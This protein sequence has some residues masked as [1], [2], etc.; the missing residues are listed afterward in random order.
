[1]EVNAANCIRTYTSRYK[2]SRIVAGG[3]HG[4]DIAPSP[5]VSSEFGGHTKRGR[6][7]LFRLASLV[8]PRQSCDAKVESPPPTSVVIILPAS[9][10]S[11]V[12]AHGSEVAAKVHN[13]ECGIPSDT[14]THT[15]SSLIYSLIR[16][17]CFVFI[18]I[19]DVCS[20]SRL[21]WPSCFAGVVIQR[22]T[23]CTLRQMNCS[24]IVVVRWQWG[25]RSNV[26]Y[27]SAVNDGR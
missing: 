17:I 24:E 3:P 7:S 21:R 20:P 1:M 25:V 18:N 4:A 27:T 15:V 8:N 22:A 26:R 10:K 6:S 16:M 14:T 13:A 11:A 9:I 5:T 12:R 2:R 19:G 23:L